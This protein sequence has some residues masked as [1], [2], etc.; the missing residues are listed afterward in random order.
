M[1]KC[2]SSTVQNILFRYGEKHD[3]DFVIPPDGHHLGQSPFDKRFLLQLPTKE[4]NILCHHTRF[5]EKGMEEVMATDSVYVSILREPVAMY[6]SVFTYIEYN[7]IYHLNEINPLKQ[8][9]ENPRKYYDQYDGKDRGKNPMLF[10]FGLENYQKDDQV[11]IDDMI[12]KLDKR[13]DLVMMTEY[14]YESLILFKDLMCWTMDDI[15]YFTLNA[16]SKDSV[17]HD[18]TPRMKEQIS[19]WNLGDVKLYDHFNKTF[20]Q[21]VRDFG[22]ERMN[23]EIT[24]LIERNEQLYTYCIA[25]VRDN[26]DRVWHPPGVKVESFE[27]NPAA[28]NDSQCVAMTRTEI[29]YTSLLQRKMKSKY[30]LT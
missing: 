5:S 28:Q 12:E 22:E 6:E 26:S 14:F 13:F 17:I 7:T 20:W 30:H 18:I 9:L 10:D 19:R 21:K 27:L 2:S 15:V 8:F 23:R 24:E 29:P 3:L 16:R 4:Y 11:L 25:Q 1:H